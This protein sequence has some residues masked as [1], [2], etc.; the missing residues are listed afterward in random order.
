MR[1]LNLLLILIF[2]IISCNKKNY[3]VK[4]YN[5]KFIKKED[6]IKNTLLKSRIKDLYEKKE[7]IEFNKSR[8]EQLKLIHKTKDSSS[9]A[10]NYEYTAS[11]F[12]EVHIPDSSYYY[13]SKSQEIYEKLK[14]S[15]NSSLML[16]NLAII[17]KNYHD[18]S[19]GEYKSL[20]AIHFLKKNKQFK[21]LSSA[22]NNLAIIYLNQK[23]YKQSLNYHL[24]ALKLRKEK[25]KNY[26]YTIH[27]LNNIGDL[28][29]EQKEYTKA[30]KYFKEAL[31]NE[32]TL[33]KYPKVKAIVLGNYAYTRFKLGETYNIEENF[34]KAL[35]FNK[36]GFKY[37]LT[38]LHLAEFYETT[39]QK[40]KA[41]KKAEQG[42]TLAKRD[43]NFIDYL[44]I[45]KFLANIHSHE[46]SK[47]IFNKL[48]FIS[49]SISFEDK[50]HRD[51]FAIIELKLQEKEEEIKVQKLNN[52]KKYYLII[53]L[54]L[55]LTL[56][57][58]VYFLYWKKTNKKVN[59]IQ[60]NS[61]NE[62]YN[63]KK[64][65][66]EEIDTIEKKIPVIALDN[67][68]DVD[69]RFQKFHKFLGE[70]YTISDVLLEYWILR[71]QRKTKTEIAEKLIKSE[72]AIASRR[73]KLIKILKEK[74][75]KTEVPKSF[76][77]DLYN[78][79]FTK[80]LKK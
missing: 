19:E 25:V 42:A 37:P 70:K 44:T 32:K 40:E 67:Q 61:Q 33:N 31:L 66:N 2:L 75:G 76:L 57:V 53:G 71:A 80:F 41:I 39:N 49:D 38:F 14:D 36:E 54:I 60:M 4:I 22:Y 47:Q 23:N 69:E 52:N 30:S 64:G 13:Y 24:N 16:L 55:L 51:S 12:N 9:L 28:Y 62:I 48:N 26:I 59:Q 3:T 77:V 15:L 72:S 7:W 46:K 18:Y 27:S 74:T 45:L 78:E 79:E 1:Y 43:K 73:K 35:A 6:S 34:I 5:R 17:H 56:M 29:L 65:Y 50:K 20:K 11:Y 21:W 8:V 58:I 68:K 63:L 10:I